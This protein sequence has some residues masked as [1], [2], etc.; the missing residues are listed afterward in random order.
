MLRV[1][2][3]SAAVAR[4]DSRSDPP[5]SH[6]PTHLGPWVSSFSRKSSFTLLCNL[7][8]YK[9]PRRMSAIITSDQIENFADSGKG[10]SRA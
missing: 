4:R 5:W 9:K 8:I 3:F 2:A 6:P 10:P 7:C 1:V